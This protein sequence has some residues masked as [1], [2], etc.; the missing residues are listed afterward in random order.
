MIET[1]ILSITAFVGTN[2]DDIFINAFLFAE[3]KQTADIRHIAIGKYLGIGFLVAVSLLGA[4]GLQLFPKQFIGWFGLIPIALGTK[5][6]FCNIVSKDRANKG[7]SI[8]V[9][10]LF[11]A[12]LITA[13]NGAD[14]IGI[15]IP[16]FANFSK[17]Q[18]AAAV[19]IFGVL[20]AVWCY[21][22]KKLSD[23]PAFKKILLKYKNALIPA[24]YIALGIYIL[25]KNFVLK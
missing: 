19:S 6:I 2:I 4:L 9:N 23:L 20:T 21:L 18:I 22:G 10:F 15:Y 17:W 24:I 5:E 25:L 12:M 13:A 11:H 16:L 7:N 1:L 8:C 14:N 3:A